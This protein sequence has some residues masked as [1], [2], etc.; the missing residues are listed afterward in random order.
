MNAGD[1]SI[2]LYGENVT[3]QAVTETAGHVADALHEISKTIAP[4]GPGLHWHVGHVDL[5]CDGCELRQPFDADRTG[6]TRVDAND[7]CPECGQGGSQ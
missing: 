7:Y 5:M 6:W 4:G 2:R 3:E 1:I